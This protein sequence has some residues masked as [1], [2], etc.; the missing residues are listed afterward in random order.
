[1]NMRKVPGT[2]L[3]VSEI[4]LGTM[5]FGT[6]VE[7]KEAIRLIHYALEKGINHIDTANMYEGYSR[8]AGS[9]GG[10]AEEIIGKALAGRRSDAIVA[11]KVGM[12]VG[13]AAEDEFT[14]P[15]AIRKQLDI[16]LSRLAT[17]Y[18][19][20][21]YLHKPD[22]ATPLEEIVTEIHHAIRAGKIRHYAVSNYDAA[23]LEKLLH[24]ADA[25]GAPR[26]V[27]CQPPMSLLKQ[28]ALQDL[29]PLCSKEDIAVAPYQI[30]Q[31]GLL[32]GKYKRGMPLPAGSRKEEKPDWLW[33]LDDALFTKLEA[34]EANASLKGLTMTQFAI[35]WIL[36]QPAVVSAIVGVKNERQID[37]AVL[38][39]ER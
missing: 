34:I 14:S 1:M 17:D 28:D 2:G 33:Q 8:V 7:E 36:E 12:K 25:C 21:Y 24:A 31:G 30:L 3:S 39:C 23:A 35:R 19:D 11:T 9:G 26:P 10:V 4:C 15:A 5:T 32:S 20:I 29:L 38:A 13:L 27:M 37:E 16:S 6:P 22:P 18:I